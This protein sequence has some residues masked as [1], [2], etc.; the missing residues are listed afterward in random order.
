M[1]RKPITTSV[2]RL[3][4]ENADLR[5]RLAEAEEILRAIRGGEADALVVPGIN[6][7]QIF[8]LKGADHSYRVLI[9][10]MNEGALTLTAEGVILYANRRFAQMLKAPLEKVIGSAIS[11]WVALESQSIIQALLIKGRDEKCDEQLVLTAGDG[12]PVS[13]YLTVSKLR[14]NESSDFFC[15]VVTDLTERIRNASIAASEKMARES[16][17]ASDQA[18]LTLQIVV[19]NLGKAEQAL[20]ESLI[21]YENIFKNVQ[22]LYYESRL[23]GTILEVSPS[24][25]ILSNGQYRRDDLLGRKITDF[26]ADPGERRSLLVALRERGRVTDHEVTLKNRDGALITCSLTAAILYDAHGQPDKIVGS[27]R[28][29]SERKRSEEALKAERGFM[30]TLIDNL[31]DNIFI[32]DTRGGILLDNLAH[33]RFLGRQEPDEVAGKTDRDFFAREL[34]DRY[35]NDERQ[36]VESGQPMIDYEEPTM[37]TDG[38]PR[39]YLTTKV[40]VRDSNGN[41]TALVGINRDITDRKKAE[42]A[43]KTSLQEKEVLLREIHHRVKNNMQVISSLFN[44]QAGYTLNHECREILK[45]GQTRIHAMSLVHEKLYK[46]RD[47]SRID[48][49]EYIQSLAVHLF[50]VYEVAPGHIHLDTEFDE[51]TLD[52]N[53]ANPCGLILNELISNA[54]KHAFPNDRTGTIK[55]GLRRRTGGAVELRVADDGIGFPKDL[56]YRQAESFGLQIVNLL[57]NQLE[58]TLELDR[59]N[60]TAFTVVFRELEYARRV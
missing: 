31:P 26:Y 1:P 27:M 23:D 10:D 21:K 54:L 22:D 5:A 32:K 2:K 14:V 45:E 60:G 55:I 34:A 51:I 47:L 36:I 25:E 9:E 46:S 6:G 18:R 16:L 20:S 3:A 38:R 29:I 43:I 49:A 7:D 13:V 17:A 48:L 42:E 44:L 50:N 58:A 30:R 35:I 37:D 52:I 19:E 53:S 8:A 39:L 57:V 40:P 15:L 4:D 33:R 12:T 11:T 28:D 56:D 24:I 59:T 41:I